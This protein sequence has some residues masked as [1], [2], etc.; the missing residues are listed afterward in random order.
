MQWL[1]QN[2][3]LIL[4]S[5]GL[6]VLVWANRG[7]LLALVKAGGWRGIQPLPPPPAPRLITADELDNLLGACLVLRDAFIR[8]DDEE[9]VAEAQAIAQRVVSIAMR[10]ADTE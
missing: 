8:M 4:V 7:Q 6:V 3:N 1:S 10:E 2:A 9:G 5:V